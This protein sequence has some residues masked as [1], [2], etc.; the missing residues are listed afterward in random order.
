MERAVEEREGGP[1]AGTIERA[2]RL[3][4]GPALDIERRKRLQG[5]PHLLEGKTIEVPAFESVEPGDETVFA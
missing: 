5:S 1:L 2:S 3:Q 4:P